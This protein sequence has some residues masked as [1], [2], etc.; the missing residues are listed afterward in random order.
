MSKEDVLN[1]AMEIVN[2]REKM[3]GK[4]YDNFQKAADLINAVLKDKLKDEHFISSTDVIF[5]MLQIKI[6]RLINDPTHTDSQ[7]DVA[8]Y[9]SL[10]SEVA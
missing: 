8:G 3:Y 1:K 6:A 4:S 9:A 5:I 10:L 7:I 2:V